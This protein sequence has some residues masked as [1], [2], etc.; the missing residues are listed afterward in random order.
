MRTEKIHPHDFSAS[1]ALIKEDFNAHGCDS[2]RPG[3]RAIAVHRFG[4]W[5]LARTSRITRFFFRQIFWYLHRYVRN[6]Y[7][8]EIMRGAQIGRRVRFVHQGGI[9]I[10]LGSKIGDNCLIRHCVTL[11]ARSRKH[12]K[13]AP[14]L[15]NNVEVGVG[16]VIIGDVIVGENAIIGAN[17]V[18]AT[19]V[20]ANGIVIP[21]MPEIIVRDRNPSGKKPAT[22]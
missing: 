10:H 12:S 22:I 6:S 11:G 20:P 13:S 2:S 14:T 21:S 17:T 3:F 5:A 7:G 9:V 16:A 4:E 18:V 15:K 19:D 1:W 8:I